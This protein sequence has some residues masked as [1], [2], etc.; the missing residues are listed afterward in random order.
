MAKA[1]SSRGRAARRSRINSSTP[2]PKPI[3]PAVADQ[4]EDLDEIL[5]RFS[6]ALALAETAYSA[7]E[8]AQEDEELIGPSVLT[9]KHGIDALN[10]VYTD[11][12]LAILRLD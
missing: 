2:K 6:D 8:A 10:H 1:H 11:L 12:D 9:L 3:K 5:G 4:V 7:L